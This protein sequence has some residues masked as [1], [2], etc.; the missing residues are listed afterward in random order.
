MKGGVE[1]LPL[2]YKR[3]P[4]RTL[5]RQ[6][7]SPSRQCR[8]ALGGIFGRKARIKQP[9]R[10]S[11]DSRAWQDGDRSK[12][13]WDAA[14]GSDGVLPATSRQPDHLS[15]SA[16]RAASDT[17]QLTVIDSF[18]RCT[19]IRISDGRVLRISMGTGKDA[20]KGNDCKSARHPEWPG[21]NLP[22]A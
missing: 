7:S 11:I 3:W 5:A 8:G 4:K 2:H 12:A 9:Q 18:P 22:S 21:G 17:G 15:H 14:S 10:M 16:H 19:S 13:R 1:L 20:F 6:G